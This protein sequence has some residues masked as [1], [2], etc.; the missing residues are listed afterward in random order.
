[1]TDFNGLTK[2]LLLLSNLLLL[3]SKDYYKKALFS[4]VATDTILMNRI[5]FAC[6]ATS[7]NQRGIRRIRIEHVYRGVSR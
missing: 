1:L 3:L 4:I 2:P 6:N 7:R 5:V